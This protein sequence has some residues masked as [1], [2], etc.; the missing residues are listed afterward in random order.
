MTMAVDK[1]SYINDLHA[2]LAL[3]TGSESLGWVQSLPSGTSKEECQHQPCG[4]QTD[5]GNGDDSDFKPV[6][7]IQPK[8]PGH[9][10]KAGKPK[11]RGEGRST[12]SA[13]AL[14]M[15]KLSFAKS[16][17]HPYMFANFVLAVQNPAMIRMK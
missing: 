2:R 15:A 12:E 5:P 17:L 9:P 10:H 1:T 4:Q 13:R 16:N 11:Q 6:L 7:N 14:Q 8:S 3:E